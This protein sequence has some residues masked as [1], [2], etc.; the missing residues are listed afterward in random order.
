MNYTSTR[1]SSLRVTAQEAIVQGIAPDGGLFVP[2]EMPS[3]T[4]ED[5]AALS[6]M[7]YTQ[8]AVWVL[9]RF[10]TDWTAEE[11][12]AAVEAAYGERFEE[13]DPA[14]LSRLEEGKYLLELWHGPTCAF[15]DMALQLLPKLLPAA[16]KKSGCREEI[17]ILVATSG[18]TGKAA[19]EG[20][21]DVPGTRILVFY[22]QEGVSRMQK[23]QMTTQQGDNVAVTGIRGNFDDAQTGVKAIFGDE[24]LAAE[25]RE[26]G[27]SLSSANSINW[28]RLVPQIV[29]YISAYCQLLADGEIAAGEQVNFCVPTGNFGNILAGYY[30]KQ[31]GL[32][33]KRF[34]CASNRNNVLT[35][36]IATGRYDR[37]RAFFTTTSPSM[38]ILISSN[39]ERLLYL[40]TG[41][42]DAETREKMD[43]LRRTGVYQ[44]D[45]REL[46]ALQEEFS[47]GCCDDRQA[48]DTIRQTF[49][50]YSYLCDPHTAVAVKVWEDYRK[51]TGDG[52]KTVILSTA[53]PYK[54]A[55]TVLAALGQPV[56]KDDFD[57]LEALEK[58][59][60][61]PAP[62][63][64]TGLKDAPCR[65]PDVCGAGEMG[66][67]VRK[68]L[69]QR[70]AQ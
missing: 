43:S 2:V 47:G 39:L 46:S 51:E 36:F 12:A 66:E 53:S 26:K 52:T 48:A 64:L 54:F 62:A 19:L 9:S 69:G 32:P 28:G 55:D 38:D 65:F 45:Q 3:L 58:L 30:A 16:A 20:F 40:L 41:K 34:L 6:G 70:E 15:K 37:N 22:P 60:G 7:T 29:Y 10:L 21:M 25:L 14:P 13:G 59:S 17:A 61:L 50:R 44:L 1:D 56:P 42:N 4:E 67:R 18:D 33:V 35:D 31:M 63:A 57:R 23:R 8:R 68:F 49:E 27:F 5:L 11:L 24:E